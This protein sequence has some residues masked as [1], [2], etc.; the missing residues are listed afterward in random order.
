MVQDYQKREWEDA[1]AKA[2]KFVEAVLKALWREAGEVVSKGRLFSAGGIL[3][4]IENKTMLVDSLRLDDS[5]C[6]PMGVRH[7]K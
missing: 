6:L 3:N 7:C 1:N 2:G 5:S 4:Q